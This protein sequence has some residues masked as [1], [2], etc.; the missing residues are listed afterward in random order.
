MQSKNW[1]LQIISKSGKSRDEVRELRSGKGGV[2]RHPRKVLGENV[3]TFGIDHDV[4]ASIPRHL[5]VTE[6]HA[7]VSSWLPDAQLYSWTCHIASWLPTREQ[8]N[9]RYID[10]GH[11][12]DQSSTTG[13][14]ALCVC[15][16]AHV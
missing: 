13:R 15:A 16:S 7:R 10:D 3:H 14:Q 6:L 8:C 9:H 1:F 2:C 12:R 11:E 4:G 5:Y